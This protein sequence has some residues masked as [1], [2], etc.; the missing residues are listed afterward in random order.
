MFTI[1]RLDQMPRHT[2]LFVTDDGA[3]LTQH[4][5][6]SVRVLFLD[7]FDGGGVLV[8]MI[9]Q[10]RDGRDY[11]TAAGSMVARIGECNDYVRRE[12]AA[13]IAVYARRIRG[14]DTAVSR[15]SSVTRLDTAQLTLPGIIAGQS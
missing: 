5:D 3:A 11:S 6:K 14:L 7:V 15:M 13:A 8:W 12:T 10:T 9:R 1:T 2:R 4:A